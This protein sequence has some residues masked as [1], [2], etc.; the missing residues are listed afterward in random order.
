IDHKLGSP[1]DWPGMLQYLLVKNFLKQGYLPSA[2]WVIRQETY[3]YLYPICQA[4][5]IQL[6]MHPNR[7]VLTGVKEALFGKF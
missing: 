2:I 3:R 5:N 4:L 6:Q 1:N 7:E